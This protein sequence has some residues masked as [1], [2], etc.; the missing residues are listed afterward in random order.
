MKK[1]FICLLLHSQEDAEAMQW[2]HSHS[3]VT[4]PA[5]EA[6]NK[7]GQEK[8]WKSSLGVCGL[9]LSQ[10]QRVII[11]DNLSANRGGSTHMSC[12]YHYSSLLMRMILT[13]PISRV[14][15]Y[16]LHTYT[17]ASRNHSSLIPTSDR[18]FSLSFTFC[19]ILPVNI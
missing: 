19:F 17:T 15:S 18:S 1:I 14:K 3:K 5:M 13:S 7:P 11:Y 10:C 2:D 16:H 6:G 12:Y 4:L 8:S 9:W